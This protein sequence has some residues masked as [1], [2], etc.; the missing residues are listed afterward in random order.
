MST[1]RLR[2][3]ELDVKRRQRRQ[4]RELDGFDLCQV[5]VRYDPLYEQG[6]KPQSP[7]SGVHDDVVHERS[8]H[9]VAECAR[10]GDEPAR[11]VVANAEHMVR[12]VEHGLHSGQSPAARPPLMLIKR[13]QL[14]GLSIGQSVDVLEHECAPYSSG[15]LEGTKPR[16][17]SIQN[18]SRHL[19]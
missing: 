8:V 19:N 4:A 16:S 17:P 3:P 13:V 1:C 11:P 6:P 7:V 5:G 15:D 2:E 9:A 10:E 14:L 18:H 12:R